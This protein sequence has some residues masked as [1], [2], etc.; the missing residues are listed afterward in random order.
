MNLYR[1][2]I[3]VLVKHYDKYDHDLLCDEEGFDRAKFG[4]MVTREA[5]KNIVLIYSPEYS[6]EETISEDDIINFYL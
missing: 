6:E 1:E 3:E 4:F 5:N 2:S